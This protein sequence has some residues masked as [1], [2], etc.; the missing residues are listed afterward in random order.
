EA[1]GI[2]F[3]EGRTQEEAAMKMRKMVLGV[4]ALAGLVSFGVAAWAQQ[5]PQPLKTT[6]VKD[7]VYW[8]QGGQ[9]SNDGFIVGNTGGVLAD[10]AGPMH[11]PAAIRSSMFRTRRSCSAGTCW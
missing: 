8:V 10:T 6:K 9:G 2:A 5:Q 7:N 11:I 3:S 4:G 1:R